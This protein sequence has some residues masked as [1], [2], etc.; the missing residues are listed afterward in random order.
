MKKT[1]LAATVAAALVS[2]Y[3]QAAVINLIDVGGVTGSKAEQ[4]FQIAADYWAK[5]LTNDATINL[6]IKF[7]ALPP[8][9]IG[10]T[11]STKSDLLVENWINGVNATKSS[12]TI[13]QTA[14]LPKTTKDFFG[15]DSIVD[16]LTAGVDINGFNDNTVTASLDGKIASAVLYQNTS[17][18]KAIGYDAALAGVVDGS[19]TFSSTFAFDFNPLNGI[20][21]GTFDFI[22]VAIHEMGHALGFVSGVDYFDLVG[23]PNGPYAGIYGDFND[24]S[25][26][27]A[28]DMFRYSA[29]GTLDLQIGGNPYFSIDGGQTA[30]FGNT[31]STGRY[32]GDG[33][34]A[35][36]WKDEPFCGAGLGIMDPTF[37]Y[38]QMGVISGLDLA[39]Y[40]AMGWNLSVD[41][42]TYGTKS[43]FQIYAEAVPEPTTWALMLGALG[44][45]V[46]LNR[47]KNRQAK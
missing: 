36:H 3:S 15:F 26:F 14:V 20:K 30:L 44:G 12:S 38:G 10:S 8:G 23:F 31:F 21:A 7:D 43:T 9:V 25:I 34:Q 18:L 1:L 19:M 32:N 40:D 13:D 5:M 4:G 46:G 35:S 29:P 45:L 27:S 47:R 41:A 2:G 24:T 37:C 22:G 17:V 28:L 6:N 39:A 11:G 16:G 33:N 42:L